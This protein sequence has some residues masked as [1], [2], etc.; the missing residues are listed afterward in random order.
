MTGVRFLKEARYTYF[1][2]PQRPDRLWCRDQHLSQ[3]VPGALSLCV[4]ILGREPD[5]SAQTSAKVK[6]GGGIRL[7]PNFSLWRV[8]R[9]IKYMDK[10]N[11]TLPL[12]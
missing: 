4:K 9:I 12:V 7:L 8:D 5:H 2:T 11:Y 10:F 3:W 6:N 1:S